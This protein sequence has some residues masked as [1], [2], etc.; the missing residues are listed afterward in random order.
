MRLSAE[1]L[2]AIHCLWDDLADFPASRTDDALLHLMQRLREWFDAGDVVWVG[3]ARLSRGPAARRDP[4]SGWRGLVVRHLKADPGTLERSARATQTQD[5]DPGLTTRALVADAGRFRIR[6][7]HDG[8][9]DMATF[10]RTA[11]Y[12]AFYE[13]VGIVD[14][15]FVAFPINADAESFYLLDRMSGSRR[16]SAAD[17]DLVGYIMRGLKWF[18]RELLLS[19]GLLLADQPLSPMERRILSLLLTARTEKEIAAEL[20]QSPSTTHKYITGIL[21]KF[22]VRGR[23][24]LLALWL[25]RHS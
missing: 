10:R 25:G 5:T 24:G 11:H 15:M 19:H 16:F 14:R 1:R 17:A 6:R 12:R 2:E 8:L 7:M 20:K 23:T 3:G 21:R 13:E 18:Q 9:V 22:G 4:Q